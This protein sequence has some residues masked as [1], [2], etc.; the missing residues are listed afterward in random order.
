MRKILLIVNH[1]ASHAS[2]VSEL[3]T[4]TLQDAGCEVTVGNFDDSQDY[5]QLIEA[6]SAVADLVIAGGGDGTVQSV[7]EHLI[8]R[9]LSM[10]IIPL[11]TAN[12]VARSLGIP[13]DPI[14]ACEVILSGTVVPMDLAKVNGR[15]FASVLGIGISTVVHEKV[16][17]K[18]KKF[19]GAV[20]YLHQAVLAFK[21]AKGGFVAQIR[22]DSV[23]L[24]VRALQ[25][26]VC[27][28]MYY[29]GSLKISEDATLRDGHL[30]LSILETKKI[31]KGLLF[32]LLGKYASR[33]SEGLKVMK[34]RKFSIDTKPRMKID[35]EG[36]VEMSTPIE[37][38][39]LQSAVRV[40]V[41]AI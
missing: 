12:N 33:H 10:G 4:K 30:H 27:N 8:G 24:K 17:S 39:I 9:K 38:E 20:S 31:M 5:S 29:G 16:E 28:G 23:S 36:S 34:S 32:A 21:S 7:A 37:V 3:I 35:V 19:W 22:G 26:T 40:H 2:G 25:I 6:H 15:V 1:K 41:P 13:K 18:S 11:G 14:K